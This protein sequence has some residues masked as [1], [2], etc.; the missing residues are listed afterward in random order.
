MDNVCA[1]SFDN[2][3]GGDFGEV[4]EIGNESGGAWPGDIVIPRS[5]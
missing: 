1:D 4:I 5:M 2:C 3:G